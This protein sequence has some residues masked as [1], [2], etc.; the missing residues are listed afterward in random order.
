M[1]EHPLRVLADNDPELMKLAE[2][3]EALE[4]S[5]GALPK[6]IKL[7]IALAIDVT[8]GAPGGVHVLARQAM[9]AGASASEIMETIRVAHFVGGQSKLY[10][11]A[12]GLK[13]LL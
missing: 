1:P 11:A 13:E 7:L 2:K 10:V 9:G 5:D 6:K 12:Q 3:A 4:F 8:I